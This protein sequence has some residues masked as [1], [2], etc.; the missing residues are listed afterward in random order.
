MYSYRFK[1]DSELTAEIKRILKVS[2]PQFSDERINKMF[3]GIENMFQLKYRKFLSIFEL[4][5]QMKSTDFDNAIIEAFTK[6]NEINKMFKLCLLWNRFDI[7]KNL[8]VDKNKADIN[9]AENMLDALKKNR[10]E[11]V[12]LFLE[13]NFSFRDF[14]NDQRLLNLYEEVLFMTL[15]I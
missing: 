6:A 3:D 9:F 7:A 1:F 13:E 2:D 8:L 4:N 11:F 5:D 14:L 15:F 10:C 12:N